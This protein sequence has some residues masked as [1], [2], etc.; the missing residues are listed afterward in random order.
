[1]LLNP[2]FARE[3][4]R[5]ALLE[6]PDQTSGDAWGL[7]SPTHSQDTGIV[8]QWLKAHLPWRLSFLKP[9]SYPKGAV[10]SIRRLISR[11]CL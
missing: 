2:K 10:S 8:R 4:A 9:L 11:P 1:M 3:K 5:E 7:M 6:Q